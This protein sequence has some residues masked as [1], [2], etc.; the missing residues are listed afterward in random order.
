MFVIGKVFSMLRSVARA[1]GPRLGITGPLGGGVILDVVVIA[2]LAGV[3]FLAGLIA[4]QAAAQRLRTRLDHFLP[5][6]FPGYAFVKGMA[7][8]MQQ[9]QEIGNSFIPVLLTF[10]EFSQVAFENRT[11][12]GRRS[13]RLPAGSAQPLVGQRTVRERGA[14]EETLDLGDG[15]AT[16]HPGK[17]LR[18]DRC[19]PTGAVVRPMRRNNLPQRYSPIDQQSSGVDS[20]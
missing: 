10:G 15:S 8:N 7:E 1:I 20:G 5:A 17:R 14:S 12:A 6:S 9:R 13:C 18:K 4:R 3:C 2:I 19:G 16:A 11:R